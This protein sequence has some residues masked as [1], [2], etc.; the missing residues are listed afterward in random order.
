MEIPKRDFF[1]L[2]SPKASCTP[3]GL[4]LLLLLILGVDTIGGPRGPCECCG[5]LQ[6]C[7]ASKQH[8]IAFIALSCTLS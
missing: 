6:C 8:A 3:Q 4:Q 2:H 1:I 5:T 7:I